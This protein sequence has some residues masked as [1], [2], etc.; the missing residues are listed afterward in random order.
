MYNS[1][2]KKFERTSK[3][4]GTLG[5]WLYRWLPIDRTDSLKCPRELG[6]R[7]S[8]Q[9]FVSLFGREADPDYPKYKRPSLTTFIQF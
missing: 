1:I 8:C 5:K 7:L 3:D 2:W 6:F 9:F 4:Q